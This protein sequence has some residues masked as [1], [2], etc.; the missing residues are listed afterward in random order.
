MFLSKGLKQYPLFVCLLVTTFFFAENL[1]AQVEFIENKGQWDQKVKFMSSAGSGSFFL[2]QNGFTIAQYNPDDVE[3]IKIKMHGGASTGNAKRNI[4]NS[5]VRQD[6]Y[7]VEFLNAHATEI[8]PDKAVP[9][10]N[11][12]FIG[13]DKSKWASN[14]KIYLGVTYK[15]MYPGID[16]RYY[17]DDAG[18]LKYDFII[19]RR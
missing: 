16:V 8:I 6:F 10:V 3:N 19:N 7:S 9:S 12:Y 14:C 1:L 17:V 18:N 13:N 15:N 11:N 5:S 4:K 2:T